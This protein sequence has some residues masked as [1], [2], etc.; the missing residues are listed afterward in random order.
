MVAIPKDAENVEA[1]YKFMNYLQKPEVMAEH[2]QRR[3]FPER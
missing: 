1:A 2:H 3:A